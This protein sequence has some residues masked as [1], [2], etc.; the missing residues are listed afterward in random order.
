MGAV[1]RAV[2]AMAE[3]E[4]RGRG[5]VISQKRRVRE[6][7]MSFIQLNEPL[8]DEK[9]AQLEEARTWSSRVISRSET[10]IRFNPAILGERPDA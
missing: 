10:A 4:A 2:Q 8:L 5:L 7:T 9:L 3:G 6:L 1:N